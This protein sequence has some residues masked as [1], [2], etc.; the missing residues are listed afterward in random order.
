MDAPSDAPF[1]RGGFT[2]E[3]LRGMLRKYRPDAYETVSGW[4][5][6]TQTD[7]YDRLGRAYAAALERALRYGA[8]NKEARP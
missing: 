5:P 1:T 2:E 8:A 3:H 4:P 7:F 6:E